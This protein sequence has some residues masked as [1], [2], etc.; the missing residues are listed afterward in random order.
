MQFNPKRE[1]PDRT[2]GDAMKLKAVEMQGDFFCG[3]SENAPALRER[4]SKKK[5]GYPR[6]ERTASPMPVV[7]TLVSPSF[8]ISPVRNPAAMV[9]STAVSMAFA[10]SSSLKE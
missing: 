1:K 3:K 8:Q 5:D 6:N 2:G 7:P 10:A 9:F 4:V